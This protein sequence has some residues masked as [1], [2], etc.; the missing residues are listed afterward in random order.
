MSL[1]LRR[2]YRLLLALAGTIMIPILFFGEMRIIAYTVDPE[3]KETDEAAATDTQNAWAGI[4]GDEIDLFNSDILHEISIDIDDEDFE[5]MLLTYQK[6]GE[7][8]YFPISITIDGYIIENAEIRLKG[9]SSL[10]SAFNMG[11]SNNQTN[12]SL[13]YLIKLDENYQG[14]Q[15]FA[16]RNAFKDSGQIN[17]FLAYEMLGEFGL[18]APRAGYAGVNFNGEGEVLYT[19][20][21][22]IDE[23]FL[24]ANFTDGSGDLF[25]TLPGLMEYLGDDPSLYTE[26]FK[27]ETNENDSDLV[28]IIAFMKF[29]EES[30][31]KEFE[32]NLE[33]YIDVDSLLKYLAFCNATVNMDSLPGTSN[34]FYLYQDPESEKFTLI[35]WDNNEI[36]GN[37]WHSGDTQAYELGL[38]FEG[39]TAGFKAGFKADASPPAQEKLPTK[40][41]YETEVTN[42][43]TARILANEKFK[44]KY[45]SYLE[46]F[47]EEILNES[48]I[49]RIDEIAE[50][51]IAENEQRKFISN[52]MQYKNGIK[53][54]KNF[55]EARIKFLQ[56]ELAGL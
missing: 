24:A 29:I 34:N 7:K 32:E 45:L 28:D 25:K 6:T 26:S 30:D 40:K 9:N 23:E 18:I 35:P 36:F 38:L 49:E 54:A 3:I 8:E 37:F 44:E 16:L 53:T 14:V 42:H 21:E 33:Q 46:E 47:M 39:N 4:E 41:Q 2:H 56:K 1:N 43:F 48:A 31:D 15:H 22:A 55:L 52:M 51:I 17:E 50:F 12:L 5:T 27:L 10:G 19:V 11:P 20:T 13:P